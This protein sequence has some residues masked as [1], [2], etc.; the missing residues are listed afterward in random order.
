MGRRRSRTVRGGSTV[1]ARNGHRRG[2][3]EAEPRAVLTN[4]ARLDDLER[5]VQRIE[6]AQRRGLERL[7]QAGD[8]LREEPPEPGDVLVEPGS[9][10]STAVNAEAEDEAPI[11]SDRVDQRVDVERYWR[12]DLRKPV[13]DRV[14]VEELWQRQASEDRHINPD[15][16]ATPAG[17]DLPTTQSSAPVPAPS[18]DE[19]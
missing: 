19:G 16:D 8:Q 5:R 15:N 14:S 1:P 10:L 18:P 12:P 3:I 17:S 4:A 9:D 11:K 6:A 7:A 13:G 2:S